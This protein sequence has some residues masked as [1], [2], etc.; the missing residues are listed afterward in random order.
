MTGVGFHSVPSHSGEPFSNTAWTSTVG[1]YDITW[2]TQAY[3][4]NANANA[5]RWGT[6]YNFRFTADVAPST[7]QITLGL[8]KPAQSPTLPNALLGDAVVPDPTVCIGDFNRDGGFDGSDIAAFFSA[9]QDG[10]PAADTNSDGGIDG[11][12]IQVF[13][14]RW[15]TSSC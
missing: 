3:S 1:T 5:L 9:W 4:V 7:G 8:F 14:E 13:F 10:I 6:L 11:G 2:K 15:S 12:D